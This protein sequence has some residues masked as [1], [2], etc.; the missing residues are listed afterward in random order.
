ML[1]RVQHIIVWLLL[2]FGGV[3]AWAQVAMPD[4]VCIGTT[5][6]YRVNDATVPSTYTWT[7]NGVVQPENG[8][9]L[10]ITWTVPG[11]YTLTV[12]ERSA[13]GCLGDVQSGWV[14][15]LSP[16]VP[17][18]GPDKVVCFG[19][20]AQ[21]S[22]SGGST[23]LWSPPTGLSSATVANPVVS[24]AVPGVYRYVLTVG[25]NNGCPAVVQDTV[26][27]TVL[28][29]LRLFAGNDTVVA[30]NQSLQLNAIDLTNSGFVQ[31]LWSPSLGLNNSGIKNP[32]A[33]YNSIPS[34]NGITYTVVARTVD[35]CEARDDIN[36]KVF[37]KADVLVPNAFTPNGDRLNDVARPILIGIKELRYF[38]IFN[39]Y[40][41]MVYTTSVQ[42]AGW[43]GTYKGSKQDQGGYVWQL[44]A[45]D[46]LG[47]VIT[48]KG[49]VV[50]IR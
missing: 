26:T 29:P 47:N 43:D 38:S 8:H 10:A 9:T 12:Q 13:N 6:Q 40:G 30:L 2:L 5:R 44:Q 37:A 35:G 22:G 15:V 21:L 3:S 32:V 41:E 28:P 20:T 25:N 18:A 50:L 39:R 23:Y 17:N 48:K 27:V 14:H 31:Y 4:T 42:G 7:V 49:V 1:K 19:G 45:V 36:I 34:G 24:I 33:L 16:P 46:L 11:I